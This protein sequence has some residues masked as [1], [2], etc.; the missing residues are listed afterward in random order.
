MHCNTNDAIHFIQGEDR[1]LKFEV[2]SCCGVVVVRD[3]A[4]LVRDNANRIVK[5]GNCIINGA[6][7]SIQ[8]SPDKAG[9]YQLEITYTVAPNTRKARYLLYVSPSLTGY[10]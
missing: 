2:T 4:Y 10:A 8:F 3:A 1:L 7:L 6:I 5:Q 9:V